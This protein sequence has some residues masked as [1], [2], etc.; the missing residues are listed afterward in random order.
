MQDTCLEDINTIISRDEELWI[1][2]REELVTTN[3]SIFADGDPYIVNV[4]PISLPSCLSPEN[5]VSPV[6]P[7][8]VQMISSIDTDDYPDL[9]PV[10]NDDERK[11]KRREQ[12]RKAAKTCREK[13]KKLADQSIHVRG[14]GFDQLNFL[15]LKIIMLKII[16]V[17]HAFF[18]YIPRLG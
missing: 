8:T 5:Q 10:I 2:S 12:N 3:R 16:N 15:L 7:V 11:L 17:E 14:I 18:K 13:K 9:M 6:T 1:W 4:N